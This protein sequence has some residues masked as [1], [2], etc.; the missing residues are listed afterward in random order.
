MN[1]PP[2]LVRPSIGEGSQPGENQVI[3]TCLGPWKIANVCS[4]VHI[5]YLFSTA[6]LS[7]VTPCEDDDD[8][9]VYRA[10][11]QNYIWEATLVLF[12][13]SLDQNWS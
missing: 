11:C 3:N 1:T 9:D 4:L 7:Q 12:V 8:D 10:S 13:S 5:I 6:P 2:D